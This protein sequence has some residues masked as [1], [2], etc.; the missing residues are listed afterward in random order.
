MIRT[1]GGMGAMGIYQLLT[2]YVRKIGN[3]VGA[4]VSSSV[5]ARA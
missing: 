1:M 2:K 3:G 5:L 4:V